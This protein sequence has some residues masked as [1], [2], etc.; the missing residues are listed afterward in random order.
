MEQRVGK[1]GDPSGVDWFSLEELR[2]RRSARIVALHGNSDSVT[3]LHA[4]GFL[5]GRKLRHRN[6]APLGDPVAFE[7]HDQRI[8]MRRAEARVVEI[9]KLPTERDG[10]SGSLDSN[11]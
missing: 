2:Q 9:E 4:L 6:T 5:P 7:I 8:S 1:T 3:R 11:E 10:A